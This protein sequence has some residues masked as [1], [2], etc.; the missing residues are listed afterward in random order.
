MS[1]NSTADIIAEEDITEEEDFAA[2]DFGFVIGFD[3]QL[4]SLMIPEHLMNDPP[5]EV[6]QILQIFGIENIHQ[7][8]NRTLH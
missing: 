2:D 1:H 3:G 4:K 7:L 8:D 5:E 6:Q